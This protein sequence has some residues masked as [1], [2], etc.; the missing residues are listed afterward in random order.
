MDDAD[1][2]GQRLGGIQT[3]SSAGGQTAA[4]AEL[5]HPLSPQLLE[6]AL[7][8][9]CGHDFPGRPLEDPDSRV[10]TRSLTLDSDPLSFSLFQLQLELAYKKVPVTFR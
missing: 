2:A 5:H 10:I 8:R 7:P 4:A 6:L 3:F 1:V 9:V